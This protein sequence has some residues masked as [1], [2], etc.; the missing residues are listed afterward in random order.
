[1][2]EK[3]SPEAA[4]IPSDAVRRFLEHCERHGNTMHSIL[5]M[6]GD[7]IFSEN[8]WAPFDRDFC[9]RMYSQTKSFVSVAIG[10]LIE[11]GRLS[12]DD[13]L[14]SYFPEEIDGT[15]PPFL[16][17]QTIRETLTM[18]TAGISESWFTSTEHDR[19]RIYFNR[20]NTVRPAGTLFEYDSPGSQVLC[21]L[22][23]K[24][25]GKPLLAFL[26]ERLFDKMGT[27]RTAY[28]L[29]TPTGVTWGDSA[30]LCTTRDIASFGRLVMQYGVYDGERLM[31]EAYLRE[32]TSRL[33]DND[34]DFGGSNVFK[35]GYGYQI[36]RAER[37]FAFVGM[38]NQ[39]TVCIPELDFLFT[40][41]ADDQGN[42]SARHLLIHSLFEE[43]V[44]LLGDPLPEDPS[45]L[46]RLEAYSSSLKLRAFDVGATT[47]QTAE[48]INGRT[49]LCE[50]NRMGIRSFSL[51]FAGD[52]GVFRYTNRTGEKEIPF[53]LGYNV[54][55]AFPEPGYSDDVGTLPK[56]GHF[57]R[58]AVSGGWC[59]ET[60]F[61]LRVQIIDKYFGNMTAYF[62]FKGDTVTLRMT[63]TAE[64]FLNEYV[65]DLVARAEKE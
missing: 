33:V 16:A 47:S 39:M 6:R 34:S 49:F 55:G 50:E 51:S 43:I 32:A 64:A 18:T 8:Y 63:K 2:F 21:H 37:G 57:Y 53:G 48:R 10:L 12:L 59:D 1:M 28:T 54:F 11:D 15:L 65:G 62:A 31:G 44:D 52:S 40:C 35:Y 38:G 36:W 45:A 58:D 14:A 61:V 46:A 22:V 9:H 5:M 4:G 30:M 24:L 42:L 41:T 27:F 60:R 7:C 56:A 19:T 13:R 29:K 23:E 25:T 3:I 20:T 17:E 26:K